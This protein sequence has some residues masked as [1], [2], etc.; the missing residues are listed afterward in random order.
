METQET[1]MEVS[2]LASGQKGKA[3]DILAAIQT[4]KQIE[5]DHRPASP[6]ERQTLARFGG[7]GAVALHLFPDPRTGKYKD[8]SW[9]ALGEALREMLTPEEYDSA[10]RTTFTAFYTSPSV[11]RAM[12][13]A[14]QRLGVPQNATV[15]EPGC[16]IGN[17]M[18]EAPEGMRFIGVELDGISGRIARA[19]HPGQDIRIENFRDTR[20]PQHRIDAVI[21]N[22]PFADVKLDFH[23]QWLSL[24]DFF[25]AKSLETLKPGGVIA[26]VTSHY[27]LD[28]QNPQLREQLAAQADF[29]GAIRLPADAFQ[30]EGTKVVTDILFLKKRGPGQEPAHADPAWL[31]TAPQHIEGV[32]IPINLYF[33]HHPEMVLGTYTRQDRLYGAETGYSVVAQG[34]LAED[35]QEA[36][37]RLPEGV[38]AALAH[39]PDTSPRSVTLPPLERHITEGSF[40]V[41][42][43]KTLMQVQDG[44][45]TPVT[46]GEKPLKADGTLIGRRLAALIAIRDQARHVLQSQN[47]GWPDQLRD[48]ARKALNRAYDSF[49]FQYGPINKTTLSVK[50]DGTTLRRMPNLVKFRGDP[51]AMLVMSLEE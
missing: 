30:R 14:L 19:L 32:D 29:L 28:K 49:V 34:D 42:D 11:M 3:R 12:H 1:T 48:E 36:I 10:K 22:V 24:H 51:D 13:A 16:G 8:D 31:Q 9:Q 23:G 39:A 38:Y 4:L 6:G 44:E 35:L 5:H 25:L 46:H 43:D 50:E 7:F 20:L 18:A 2:P 41:G 17:F 15:L 47:E 45:A 26:V 33:Q 37:K 27:T 21:G 40:F